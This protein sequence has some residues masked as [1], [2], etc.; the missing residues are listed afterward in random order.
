MTAHDSR[1]KADYQTKNDATTTLLEKMIPAFRKRLQ[2][3]MIQ[4]CIATVDSAC[5]IGLVDRS[6]GDYESPFL[7]PWTIRN[8]HGEPAYYTI[9]FSNP[10]IYYVPPLLGRLKWRI[11]TYQRRDIEY[12][13]CY[14]M[15]LNHVILAKFDPPTDHYGSIGDGIQGQFALHKGKKMKFSSTNVFM[16][17]SS[18]HQPLRQGTDV[19]SRYFEHSLW[20]FPGAGDTPDTSCRHNLVYH[21]GDRVKQVLRLRK[22]LLRVLKISRCDRRF[23]LNNGRRVVCFHAQVS[24]LVDNGYKLSS[25]KRWVL[26]HGSMEPVVKEGTVINAVLVEPDLSH[27]EFSIV[28]GHAGL[29]MQITD[30]SVLTTSASIAMWSMMRNAGPE[31]SLTKVGDTIEIAEHVEKLIAENSRSA[32]IFEVPWNVGGRELKR[33]VDNLCP[34]FVRVE[35]QIYH[36]PPPVASFVLTASTSLL[37]D[38]SATGSLAQIFDLVEPSVS[39]WEQKAIYSIIYKNKIN[40]TSF[41]NSLIA[42]IPRLT[43]ESI[44]SRMFNFQ[45]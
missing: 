29:P 14:M 44:I 9:K 45:L 43:G 6:P 39:K 3:D 19:P 21:S 1:K 35:D 40:A 12:L 26:I 27:P 32:G 31:S 33:I 17:G 23:I 41:C 22:T 16:P 13:P 24:L 34:L 20:H 5:K 36:T 30:E 11:K 8:L 42:H 2:Q 10:V 28:I 25:E 15:N 7:K 18:Q 37:N 38:R 4:E